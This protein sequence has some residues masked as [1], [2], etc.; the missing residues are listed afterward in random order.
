M[1]KRVSCRNYIRNETKLQLG[2]II[3]IIASIMNDKNTNLAQLFNG[4]NLSLVF[5]QCAG[6]VY[7]ILRQNEPK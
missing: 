7:C 5:E 3:A 2:K 1:V 6:F 4:N